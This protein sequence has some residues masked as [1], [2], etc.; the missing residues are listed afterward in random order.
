MKVMI[1]IP[2][3]DFKAVKRYKDYT[4]IPFPVLNS[5][6]RSVQEGTPVEKDQKETKNE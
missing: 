6:I 5:V 3:V 1:N 2:D 4:F